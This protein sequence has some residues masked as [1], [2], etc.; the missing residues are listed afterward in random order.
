VIGGD[1]F[2]YN[3]VMTGVTIGTGW[4]GTNGIGRSF[5]YN[6]ALKKVVVKATRPADIGDDFYFCDGTYINCWH[7]GFKIYV[8]RNSVDAYKR[9]T[10]WSHYEE[11]IEPIS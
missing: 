1:A 9:A 4:T 10:N 5:E 6:S 11:V 8:P 3:R 2:S 7:D